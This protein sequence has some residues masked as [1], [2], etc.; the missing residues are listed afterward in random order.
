VDADRIR[1][2]TGIGTDFEQFAIGLNL[3][4]IPEAVQFVA[5]QTELTE[6]YR[7]LHGHKTRSAV[8]LHGL[9]G[10]GKTQLAIEY[11]RRHKEKYTAIFWLNANDEDSLRLSFRGVAQQVLKHH[12]STGMPLNVDLEGDLDQVVNTVK[13]WLDLRKNSHWLMIYDNYDNP[14][15]PNNSDR[16]AVDVRQ[17]LPEADHGSI[18]ITTRSANVTQGQRLHVQKL[19]DVE[20]GLNILSNMSGRTGIENGMSFGDKTSRIELTR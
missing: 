12:P 2:L 14:R 9:G 11:V 20:E 5:R 13:V 7:L 19:L 17:Y 10:I 18:I 16:L 1:I 15:T 8:V 6:M 4:T 3:S